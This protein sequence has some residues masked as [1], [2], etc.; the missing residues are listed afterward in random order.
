M[1]GRITT[2]EIFGFL[3]IKFAISF[4]MSIELLT[5]YMTGNPQYRETSKKSLSFKE[6]VGL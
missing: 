3:H 4:S 6:S 2:L 1:S 5:G